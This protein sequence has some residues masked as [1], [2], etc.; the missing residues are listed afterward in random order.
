M[1]EIQCSTSRVR[2]KSRILVKKEKERT[3]YHNNHFYFGMEGYVVG[4][5]SSGKYIRLRF[6]EHGRWRGGWD[7]VLPTTI[8]KTKPA[9]PA[10]ECGWPK[11]FCRQC[12][13]CPGCNGSKWDKHSCTCL[14]IDDKVTVLKGEHMGEQ[15]TVEEWH[16]WHKKWNVKLDNVFDDL[17]CNTRSE[18]DASELAT[19]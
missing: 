14:S 1:G 6:K 13:I 17:G 3:F 18:Y 15:G 7:N 2:E 19:L 16:D 10:C 12:F 11:K 9:N 5:S 4:L 8:S